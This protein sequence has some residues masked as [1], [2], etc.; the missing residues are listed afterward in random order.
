MIKGSPTWQVVLQ[1]IFLGLLVAVV[2]AQAILCTSS[3]PGQRF[4][5]YAGSQI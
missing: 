3:K 1:I 4:F 5:M 2:L